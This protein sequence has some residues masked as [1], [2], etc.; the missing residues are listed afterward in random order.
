MVSLLINKHATMD[1]P[2]GMGNV[3]VRSVAQVGIDETLD[4]KIAFGKKIIYMH[5]SLH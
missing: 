5:L 1:T 2:G 3:N 4:F